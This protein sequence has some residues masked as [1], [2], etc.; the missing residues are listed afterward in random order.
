MKAVPAPVVRDDWMTS[1]DPLG[2]IFGAAVTKVV[3]VFCD[4]VYCLEDFIY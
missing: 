4:V 1:G 2:A 3:F